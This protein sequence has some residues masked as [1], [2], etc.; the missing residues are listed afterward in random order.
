MR[1]S[2]SSSIASA[3]TWGT[4][5]LTRRIR[6]L[7]AVLKRFA[8]WRR[9]SSG[10]TICRST[11]TSSNSWLPSQ[12]SAPSRSS[13]SSRCS[14]ATQATVSRARCQS[15]WWSTSATDAP[16]RR[17]SC[18]LTESSSLRLPFSEWFSGKWSS[19]ER[20][21]TQPAPKA[22]GSGRRRGRV[23]VGALDLTRFV[24]LEHVAFPEVVE[25]LEQDAA[26][27]ALLNLAH[28]VLEALQLRDLRLVEDRPVA[29]DADARVPAHG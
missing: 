14:R 18:A 25:A 10:S 11:R 17:C 13:S 2:L 22:L 4:D 28:V 7:I 15:S 3:R 26:L 24:D 5:S 29:D 8:R 20:M 12:R 21:P 27:E 9:H 23:E 19:A 6:P 1:G 16:K